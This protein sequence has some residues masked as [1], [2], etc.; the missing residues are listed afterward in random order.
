V[1]KP[2]I[3]D[4]LREVEPEDIRRANALMSA[5]GTLALV[6]CCAGNILMQRLWIW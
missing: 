5:A 4:P 6:L 2:A 1:E 3:G